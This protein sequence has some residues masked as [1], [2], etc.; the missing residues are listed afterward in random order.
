M[1]ITGRIVNE[2]AKEKKVIKN[3]QSTSENNKLL[4]VVSK[5]QL[6]ILRLLITQKK[7][8]QV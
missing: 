6:Q 2:S 3:I 4:K 1:R 7:T 8:L 5:Q